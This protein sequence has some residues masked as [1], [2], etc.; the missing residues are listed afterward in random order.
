MRTRVSLVFLVALATFASSKIYFHEQFDRDWE[1]RWQKTEANVEQLGTFE[2]TKGKWPLEND[3]AY[4]IQT[5]TDSKFYEI[6]CRLPTP[7]TTGEQPLVFQYSLKF[8]ND[9][10]CGGG[11]LK[12]IGTDYKSEAFGADTPVLIMFGPDVCGGDNKIH[13]MLDFDGKGKLWSKTPSAPVDHLTHVYTVLIY[14][15]E[16]YEVYVDTVS[17]GNG[18]I[19]EDWDVAIPKM[20]PDP[21]DKKPEDWDDNMYLDDPTSVKPDDWVDVEM[22]EDTSATKPDDWDDDKE[23]EWKPPMIKNPGYKGEWKPKKIYN[24]N[25]KGVWTPKK[26]PN[27]EYKGSVLKPYTIG[28]IGIDVW[29]VRHGTIFD[30]MLLTDSL[31]EAFAEAK[32]IME[33]QVE[34]EKVFYEKE[35]KEREEEAAKERDASKLEDDEQDYTDDVREDL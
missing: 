13:L 26:I 10:E 18:T 27:P 31:E 15:N 4:G 8:E 11:Y 33:I 2:W 12:L 22:I 19:S 24:T 35:R 7:V 17:V 9:I 29:Q 30:N 25:Y 14:P 20:I 6:S 34:E 16:T 1:T 28:G 21:N 5:T 3:M 23:G 32:K